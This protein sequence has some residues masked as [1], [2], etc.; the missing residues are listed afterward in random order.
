MLVCHNT[1]GLIVC[2]NLGG[3]LVCHNIGGLIVCHNLG[4]LIV[5]HNLKVTTTTGACLSKPFRIDYL[6][7]PPRIKTFWE[8]GMFYLSQQRG[9]GC[10]SH[11]YAMSCSFDV[12]F[13][14]GV[15]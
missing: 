12:P 13:S 10:L 15:D 1:G 6:S 2:H 11:S 7:Q 9:T 14:Q 5:F 4:G 8:C 3:V